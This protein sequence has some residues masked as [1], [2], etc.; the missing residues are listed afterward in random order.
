MAEHRDAVGGSETR[1][2]EVRLTNAGQMERGGRLAKV[3]PV[4]GQ[5]HVLQWK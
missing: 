2:P 5:S 4:G 1:R 3:W